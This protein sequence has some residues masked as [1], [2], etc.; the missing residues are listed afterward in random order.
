[1]LERGLAAKK[2]R[3]VFFEERNTIDVYI[4]DT[5]KGYKKIYKC[6]LNRLIGEK[7]V[8]SDVFPLG[9]KSHVLK[10]WKSDT[11]KRNRPRVYIVDGDLS[12]F[13]GER[14]C[15]NGLYTLPY[16]CLENVFI[17]KESLLQILV[18]EDPEREYTEI[19]ELLNFD[20]WINK[21][22]RLF[23]DLFIM[24]ALISKYNAVT[25]TINYSISNLIDD[26]GDL[27]SINVNQ[28][29]STYK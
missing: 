23:F 16:Y 15:G 6:I 13:F 5:A 20:E 22:S 4:E 2:A 28:R 14:L 29:K 12:L 17:C 27:D 1:M 10:A 11:N 7:F 26:M 3:S 18:E 21:N 8:V 19:N 25:P 24:Y 9:G